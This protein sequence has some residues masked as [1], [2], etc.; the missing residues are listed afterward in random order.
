MFLELAHK[1]LLSA[2]AGKISV[3][4]ALATA[5]VLSFVASG[6]RKPDALRRLAEVLVLRMQHEQRS[7]EADAAAFFGAHALYRFDMAATAGDE[8][9]AARMA[10]VA[11]EAPAEAVKLAKDWDCDQNR[12]E[13][14]AI[15]IAALDGD[16]DAINRV[17]DEALNAIGVERSEYDMLV[18]AEVMARLGCDLGLEG[19]KQRLAWV[20]AR[21]GWLERAALGSRAA[22]RFE[23]QVLRLLVDLEAVCPDA[24]SAMLDDVSG[25]AIATGALQ[26][27]KLL[28]H[29]EPW[30]SC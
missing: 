21:R 9:S 22:V 19:M 29:L 1:A 28:A 17:I 5:E 10:A 15:C 2:D 24:L 23:E 18:A 6:S 16:K 13:Y 12:A 7:N 26:E 4:E 20:L 30:G 14:D 8:G 11:D 25:S 3:P 27:P